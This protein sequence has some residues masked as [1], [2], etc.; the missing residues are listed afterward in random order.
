MNIDGTAERIVVSALKTFLAQGVRRSSLSDIAYGAG[1][2]RIT[3]Y[4]YFGD[5]EGIVAAACRHVASIFRRAA[6]GSPDDSTAQIDIRLKRMGE[7]LAR[8][9][10]G[11]LLAQFDEIRRLYP[12]VYEEFR[13]AR[14]SALDQIFAQAVTAALRGRKFARASIFKSRGR[15]FGLASWG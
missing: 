10:P 5:K 6:E 12:A 15:C 7:E 11:N 2:T 14:E 1:V 3:V 13:A 9:P 4:R 8:L